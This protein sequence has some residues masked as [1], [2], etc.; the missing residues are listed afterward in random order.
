[1]I[2]HGIQIAASYVFSRQQSKNPNENN[3]KDGL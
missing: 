1:M 3:K 2:E